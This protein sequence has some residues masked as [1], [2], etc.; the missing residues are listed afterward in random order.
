MGDD[1]VSEFTE[2]VRASLTP[3]WRT[4][5]EIAD[6]MAGRRA[7]PMA[8]SHVYKVLNK[9]ARRGVAEKRTAMGDGF[10]QSWWRLKA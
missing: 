2:A 10:R 3:E 1:A 4:T 5:R 6:G 9:L 8:R 7:D